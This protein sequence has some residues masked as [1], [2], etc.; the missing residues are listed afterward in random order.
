[1]G[2]QL[3]QNSTKRILFWDNIKGL[4]IWLVVFGHFVLDADILPGMSVSLF[5]IVWSFIYVF[6]MPAF[7]FVSGVLSRND[8]GK[9]LAKR[10]SNF[11]FIGLSYLVLQGLFS[12]YYYLHDVD[13]DILVPL[14]SSWYLLALFVWRVITPQLKKYKVAFPVS[15]IVSMIVGFI[16]QLD[17]TFAIGRIIAFY[18]FYLA[19]FILLPSRIE[20]LRSSYR[21]TSAEFITAIVILIASLGGGFYLALNRLGLN[22]LTMGAYQSL[23]EVIFR[24]LIFV[25]AG[26]IIFGLV[27]VTP[28][29][30]IRF[31]TQAGR[32]SF[33]IFFLHRFIVLFFFDFYQ[34]QK[35]NLRP[36]QLMLLILLLSIVVFLVLSINKI[37]LM[38]KNFFSLNDTQLTYKPF[39]YSAL[40]ISVVLILI[41]QNLSSF[42]D[43][44]KGEGSG[45]PRANDTCQV[46]SDSNRAEFDDCYKILFA[47]DLI[48]LEDQ[49]KGAYTGSEYCF[50]DMFEYTHKYIEEADLSIGVFEG[51]MAGDNVPYSQSNYADGKYMYL[52]FPDSFA[53]AVKKAGFDLVTLANNHL[54]D[55][56]LE[57]A[58]RTM[59][60]MDELG[61]SYVGAYRDSSEKE[62]NH[63][64]IIENQGM[65]FAI[66][67]YTFNFNYCTDSDIMG[68]LNFLSSYLVSP[69][70]EYYEK[71][72]SD[73]KTDFE[74]AKSMNPDF[75]VVLPHMGTQFQDY[76]DY[77]Q[78]SWCDYFVEL[79]AD[80]ILGDHT[81]SVQP[82]LVKAVDGRNVFI[83]YC[84]GNYANIYREYNGDCSILT[85]V[86]IDRDSKTIV[87]GSFIPMWVTTNSNS[88]FRPIPIYDIVSDPDVSSTLTS[89]DMA[90]V[91]E[92]QKHITFVVLG[93]EIDINASRERYYFNNNGYL[94]E[95]AVPLDITETMMDGLLY[96]KLVEADG[97]CFIGDSI[98]CGSNNFGYPW[99]EPI[100]NLISGEIV[101]VARGGYTVSQVFELL[102]E[103]DIK[104]E[105]LFVI[106]LGTN[107]I[108]YNDSDICATT[109]EEYI[110]RIDAVS[111]YI[112]S[113]NSEAEI[114]Y[115]APWISFE[116]DPFIK[117]PYDE[118]KAKNSS[119]SL[120]LENYCR[121]NDF[122][123]INPNPM[124]ETCIME[125]IQSDYLVD[126][127]HPNMNKGINLYS[128]AVLLYGA[129]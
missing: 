33:A 23:G 71:V 111:S 6:H 89:Y 93:V 83:G 108:R 62:E 5:N 42:T 81:H 85:E 87:G 114:V 54:M 99:Y 51:P 92:V 128:E 121:E 90:R 10:I 122:I 58:L 80:I 32:N 120:A 60:V 91:K 119:F 115:I 127:I 16:P 15:I 52:N 117:V 98:T 78:T 57:G 41:I 105:S 100:E 40:A 38:L 82:A 75:I 7:I 73:I 22:V 1:M 68:D 13:V 48:L 113:V 36:W 46:M 77:Y 45:L 27:I 14:Y 55:R 47:G 26:I 43:V 126:W 107:D 17:R 8:A 66:L 18:P 24:L 49:V 112:L 28:D 19:G 21:K 76:P 102:K 70:S 67:S 86:Y 37:T 109:S 124:I 39:V 72:K 96:K 61:L 110:K 103:T 63:V 97:V 129:E 106:A 95:K 35:V 123:Y 118:I 53:E 56:G 25:F 12:I 88:N 64:R 101:N 31:L 50:D 20:A 30:E 59:D 9:P 29:K 125:N 94:R 2:Q 65:T 79:G 11:T 104:N 84:P 3:E 34:K 74:L 69:D 4:L 44:N 116:N